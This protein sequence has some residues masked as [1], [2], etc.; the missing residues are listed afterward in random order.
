MPQDDSG[1]ADDQDQHLRMTGAV[2]DGLRRV[3][4][5]ARPESDA[6]IL[7]TPRTSPAT[8]TIE[9][10]SGIIKGAATD[11]AFR[12]PSRGRYRDW[13]HLCLYGAGGG[14]DLSVHRQ[15]KFRTRRNGDALDIHLLAVDAVGRVLLVGVAAHGDHFF[16]WGH[17]YRAAARLGACR[18]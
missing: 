12:Q 6:E 8:E 1:G 4:R 13:R 10:L 18:C 9:I 14:H 2:V 17:H 16:C 15:S 7:V 11:G 3:D 5:R